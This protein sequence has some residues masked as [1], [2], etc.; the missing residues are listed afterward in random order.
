MPDEYSLSLAKTIIN[1]CNH[2][3][4]HETKSFV[5]IRLVYTSLRELCLIFELLLLVEVIPTEVDERST[6][7]EKKTLYEVSKDTRC[8]AQEAGGK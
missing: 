7:D 1:W 4:S 2:T 3:T 8:S 6:R 5:D